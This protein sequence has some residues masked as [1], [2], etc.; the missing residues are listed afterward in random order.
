MSGAL[1]AATLNPQPER[2]G[3]IRAGNYDSRS[4]DCTP[5]L[6]LINDTITGAT[7][8]VIRRDGKPMSN[9]DLTYAGTFSVDHT[10]RVITIWL[11]VGYT[12]PGLTVEPVDYKVTITVQ[13]L[14]NRTLSWDTYQLVV[15]EIG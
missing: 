1:T 11:A 3:A 14:G 6:A 2:W 12:V 9:Q 10:L 7:C 5:D 15:S 8:T 13:T 4:R